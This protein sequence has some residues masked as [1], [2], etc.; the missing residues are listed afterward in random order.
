[1]KQHVMSCH[2]W[3]TYFFGATARASRNI[4]CC[5]TLETTPT[6]NG[7]SPRSPAWTPNRWFPAFFFSSR[8]L[9]MHRVHSDIPLNHTFLD[10]EKSSCSMTM[11]P[12]AD[13]KSY[14]QDPGRNVPLKKGKEMRSLMKT[15]RGLKILQTSQIPLNAPFMWHTTP[16]TVNKGKQW[17]LL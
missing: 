8:E 11:L 7:S 17:G 13:Q 10:S 3:K 6:N 2:D 9:F 16:H 12:K 14:H 1:M 4:F 15:T 5:I